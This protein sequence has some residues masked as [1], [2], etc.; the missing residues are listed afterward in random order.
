MAVPDEPVTAGEAPANGTAKNKAGA[1]GTAVSGPRPR[2]HAVFIT[3]GA[4]LVLGF[5]GVF[6]AWPVVA[7]LRLGLGS[8][9]GAVLTA[10]ETWR[11]V[12]FTLGQAAASTVLAIVAGM[13]LAYLLA[14]VPVPGKALLRALITVPFV[15]PTLVVGMAF[16]A[17]LGTA[18]PNAWA[19]VLANAF[20]N[21]AVVARTVS[22]LWTQ[23]DPRAT[24][25]A[26]SLG[27][28]PLRAFR[29]VTLPALRPALWSAAAVVFLFCSTSFGV[30]L[31]LGGGRYRTLETE[32]Y[33]RTVR[34]LDLSGAAALSLL[35][36]AAVLAAL[37]VA[38]F[39]R[40]RRENVLALRRSRAALR[41]PIGGEWVPVGCAVVV[42]GAL[43]APIVALLVRSVNARG[44]WSLAGYR[45]LSGTGGVLDVSGWQAAWNS[46]RTATDA[47]WMSLLLGVLACL[48]L[49]SLR[50][51][52]AAELMDAALMLPLGVSA[53]TVG[54]GYLVTLHVLPG[55]L[56]TSPL[57]V[58]FA[59]ALVI[60]PLVIRTILPVLRSVDRRVRAAAATLGAGPWRIRREVDLPLA[61]RAVVTAAGFGFVVALGEFGATGFLA[62]PEA[63]TL[64]VAISTL[65]SRPGELN[66][67]MAYAACALLMLVTACAVLVIET[68]RS[69]SSGE[70]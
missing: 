37:A 44:G 28:G 4:A 66:T 57:L 69:D 17:L 6:F 16:R 30:V 41:R 29:T 45:A 21:V 46:L 7:I 67:Q 49:T 9:L 64:P 60:T 54:F 36:F 70:F 18:E 55:D 2:G 5:L 63:P 26:R 58:P 27:A 42:L 22:G 23:L 11:I 35:Q 52:W 3:V 59:Q 10:P 39:A 56:R 38:A 47:T 53:V 1:D 33:L 15:L 14:R 8:G 25:A 68:L 51:R 43:A 32:I 20:F 65:L 61:G 31:V 62:R 34:L 24:D 40:G 50:S 13:P 48:V 19:I 12:A